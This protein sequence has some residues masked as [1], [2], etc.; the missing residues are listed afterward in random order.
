MLGWVQ[1]HDGGA[2]ALEHVAGAQAVERDARTRGDAEA[3]ALA[4]G[5]ELLVGEVLD[6]GDRAL[7]EARRVDRSNGVRLG[8][9]GAA[10]V[11]A[12]EAVREHEAR[13]ALA[14]LAGHLQA[15]AGAREPQH[16]CTGRR[17]RHC[18]GWCR[19]MEVKQTFWMLSFSMAPVSCVRTREN[20][21]ST[22]R[23]GIGGTASNNHTH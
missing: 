19:W 4:H 23:C 17:V 5:E 3:A 9:A 20:G 7:D 22:W 13:A 15:L 10:E 12:V 8:A 6:A 11:Q 1:R 2:V 21:C 14:R 16:L 18:F